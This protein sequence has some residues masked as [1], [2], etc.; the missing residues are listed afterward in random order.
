MRTIPI[1]TLPNQE[2]SINVEDNRWTIRLKVAQS[3]ICAD[4]LLNDESLVLGQRIA[5]GT[6]IIP[7]DHLATAGNFILL[8]EGEDLP[9]WRKFNVSQQLLYI[10]PG[11]LV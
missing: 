4:I 8:V 9:D 1:D 6:P 2:L 7:Y 3:S 10:S 5:V 11:E